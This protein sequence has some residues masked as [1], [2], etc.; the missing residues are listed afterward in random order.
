MQQLE[1]IEVGQ[2][3]NDGTG[4]PLRNGMSKV[5]DNF[6]KV[7]AGVD[8][9]ESGVVQAQAT[10]T[11]AKSVADGAVPATEK[12]MAG[13]VAPLDAAGK[14]PTAY[15]PAQEDYIPADQKGAP[16]G[17]APLDAGG[18][19]PAANL[20]A[21]EDSIPL[22]QK[23]AA[24]GVATLDN[25]GQVPVAQLGG[26]VK[27]ADKG[28][29]GG[30]ATLDGGG[31]VPAGQLP[32]I[33]TG[34]AVGTPAW[35]P[36]R[37]AIPAGQIPQDGQTVTRATY[38]D[39]TAM[40]VAGKLPVVPEADWLADP[41]KRGSYTLGD[42]STTIR[43]PDLNGQAAGSVGAVVAR[44]DGARSAGTAG[45]IQRDQLGP[46]SYT[47]SDFNQASNVLLDGTGKAVLTSGVLASSAMRT[48]TQSGSGG[49]WIGN[50][51]DETRM[52]NA[53]GVWTVH[54]F[55]AVTNPGAVDA[56]QLASDY[57]ALNAAF[58]ALNSAINFT[59]VYPNNG[60]A[61]APAN[62]T[63]NSR[64]VVPNPFPGSRVLCD[65]EI[66]VNGK[67]GSPGSFFGN[68]SAQYFGCRASQYDDGDLVVQTA[69]NYLTSDNPA[70]TGHPFLPWP[71]SLTTAPARLK[72]WRVKGLV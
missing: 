34:P 23:G 43:L 68:S 66:R 63:I 24:G 10:A 9:V 32:P 13:G 71:S 36:S 40:V 35:W 37:V 51:G 57:A 33:P 70:A 67:W 14:V 19:V 26:A 15:L 46:M 8:A 39:L 28:A 4:D 56:A 29:A 2:A 72:V 55:G 44:G 18:K 17:V 65:L 59:I 69:L 42:G 27:A 11:A 64:Y 1:H 31:K 58:Q 6:I 48:V 54:A 25:A 47:V 41:L 61:A 52:L 62:I 49:K 20:P 45:A 38:P 16:G 50:T 60:S 22:T 7:Q 12:G 5:N 21:A 30:V 53:T 3:A